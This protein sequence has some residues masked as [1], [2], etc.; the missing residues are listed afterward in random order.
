[1]AL[2]SR[3]QTTPNPILSEGVKSFLEGSRFGRVGL[4]I[5]RKIRRSLQKLRDPVQHKVWI[6]QLGLPLRN[7]ILLNRRLAVSIGEYPVFLVPRG[8]TAGDMW[9]GLRCENHEIS[10]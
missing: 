10:L 9:A 4:R 2:A 6:R 7:A 5:G 3:Q 8:S 1:M